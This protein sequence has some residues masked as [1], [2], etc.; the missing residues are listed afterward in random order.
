M[1]PNFIILHHT[2]VSRTKNNNQFR[3]VNNYHKNKDW[4]G[5][6]RCKKSKTGYYTQYHYFCDVNGLITQTGELNEVKWHAGNQ[7]GKS[8][9]ICI[10]GNFDEEKPKL[11]QLNSLKDLL[12]Y[13]REKFG[14]K[15]EDL[16]FHR[17]FANKTCPGEN[18]TK[19]LIYKYMPLIEI[20]RDKKGGYYV[21]KKNANSKQKIDF[22]NPVEA[23]KLIL[24]FLTRE[25]GVDTI[26]EK[27][28]DK[29]EDVNYV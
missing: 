20:K 29:L 28:L 25:F 2:A 1:K 3:A 4:G 13:L 23:N 6:A 10:A 26:S 27:D 18:I 5:G 21:C 15:R 24:T 12:R 11:E 8:I 19:E 14:F 22:D 9:G 17:E 16:K 7:N